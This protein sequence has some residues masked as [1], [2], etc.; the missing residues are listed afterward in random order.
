MSK[1][2][3]ATFWLFIGFFVLF[4]LILSKFIFNNP[5]YPERNILIVGTNSLII[6]LVIVSAF[7]YSAN[8][9]K[10]KQTPTPS[11]QKS[12]SIILIGEIIYQ[13]GNLTEKDGLPKGWTIIFENAQYVSAIM[14]TFPNHTWT[15]VNFGNGIVSIDSTDNV[16]EISNLKGEIKILVKYLDK[17]KF[18]FG[19]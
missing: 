12:D 19:Y 8:H 9:A 18:S 11:P 10:S 16:V 5:D 1:K 13:S 2:I 3:T 15:T 4:Y 14:T 7:L 17:T 6:S